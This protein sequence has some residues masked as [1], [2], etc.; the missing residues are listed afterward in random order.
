MTAFPLIYG[1][2]DAVSGHDFLA[3]VAID[4]RALV[5]QEDTDEWWMY[6]VT[7]GGLAGWGKTLHEAHAA[8]RDAYRKAL[9]D[10]AQLSRDF[11]AFRAEVERFYGESDDEDAARWS[12]AARAIRN[13][14]L[15]PAAAVSELPRV[16]A[17]EH[18]CR[19]RLER[20]DVRKRAFSPAEN[21][22][23]T[24]AVAAEAA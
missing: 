12:E 3:G 14:K 7:P 5:V 9:F 20:L 10:I 13:G 18:R 19:L 2:R 15:E 1:F 22:V 17:E 4:G 23:D 21:K 8:F 16:K 6:G 24:Y 11:D